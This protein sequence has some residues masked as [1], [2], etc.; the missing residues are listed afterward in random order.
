MVEL[1]LPKNSRIKAGKHYK[2][3]SPGNTLR[4]FQVYRWNPDD[5]D[6][7]RYD[8]YEEHSIERPKNQSNHPIAKDK[9]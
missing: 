3:A 9:F 5:P 1:R 8:T 6:N 2:A 7:P 4:T